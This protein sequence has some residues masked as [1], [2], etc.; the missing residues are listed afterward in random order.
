MKSKLLFIFTI[1]LSMAMFV[2]TADAR[3]FGGGRSFGKSW[4]APSHRTSSSF[5]SKS[6]SRK[7]SNILSQPKRSGM[8]K[9]VLMG[10]LAGG[11]LGSLLGGSAFQGLQGLDIIIFVL[12]AFGLFR[13][14]QRKK[15]SE[16]AYAGS[17]NIYHRENFQHQQ[18]QPSSFHTTS[19]INE[20]QSPSWFNEAKFVKGAKSHFLTLQKA[21]DE[22]DLPTI[23]SYCVPE[24]YESIAK[25]RM[26]YAGKQHTQVTNLNARLLDIVEEGEHVVAGI[27][28]EAIIST[29][30]QQKEKV[31]EVWS[32]QH[33]KA[34]GH[35]DWLIVGIEQR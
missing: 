11:L 35:G 13:L 5:F 4:S 6:T 32:I 20:D 27:E 30:N 18:A 10:L 33:E 31:R 3:R 29:N 21:W 26:D 23:Q 9:G 15:M 24:L 7:P 16:N 12:I 17:E 34:H 2:N 1:F 14:Y 8:L 22:N 19:T 25:E 28:F